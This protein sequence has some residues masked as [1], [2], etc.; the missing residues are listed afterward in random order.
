[1]DTTKEAQAERDMVDFRAAQATLQ[2]L[3]AAT[4]EWE[5]QIAANVEGIML[6]A[7]V[8]TN[9]LDVARKIL[10]YIVRAP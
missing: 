7:P 10:D 3:F 1:M 8:G 6:G 4:P 9:T 5:T 2:R